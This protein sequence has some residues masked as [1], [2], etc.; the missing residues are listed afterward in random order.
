MKSG[1]SPADVM[2]IAINMT[3]SAAELLFACMPTKPELGKWTK[4]P[5]ALDFFQMACMPSNLLQF[6]ILEAGKKIKIEVIPPDR[7]PQSL[8]FAESQCLRLQG[9]KEL[10]NNRMSLL[11]LQVEFL[12][13]NATRILHYFYFKASKDLQDPMEPA[14]LWQYMDLCRSPALVAAQYIGS[15]AKGAS[16]HLSLL[17]MGAGF[18]SLREWTNERPQEAK[19]C[20]VTFYM[21]AASLERRNL[22]PMG[23]PTYTTAQLADI[24]GI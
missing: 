18:R 23:S 8:S 14:L 4:T 21:V 7:P 3:K 12:A 20:R 22:E 2:G 17:W 19:L 13:S 6:I 5:M 10:M 11:K 24:G 15:L 9:A 1:H 16:E